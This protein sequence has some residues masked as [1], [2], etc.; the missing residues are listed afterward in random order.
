MI[1]IHSDGVAVRRVVDARQVPSPW[2]REL[3]VVLAEIDQTG[4]PYVTWLWNP[5]TQCLSH[6]HYFATLDAARDDFADR[7]ADYLF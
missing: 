3:W 1:T 4:H 5:S 6:G 2:A 7:V